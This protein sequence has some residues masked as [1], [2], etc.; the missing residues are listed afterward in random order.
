MTAALP[1]IHARP[2]PAAVRALLAAAQ[3]ERDARD[4]AP[5]VRAD[6]NDAK[7]E[8]ARDRAQRYRKGRGNGR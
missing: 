3:G 7:R 2:D 6:L 5:G 1:P 4:L 8:Q